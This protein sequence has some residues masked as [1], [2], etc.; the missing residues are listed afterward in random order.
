MDTNIQMSNLE[1][2]SNASAVQVSLESLLLQACSGDAL[3]LAMWQI[4]DKGDFRILGRTY[5]DATRF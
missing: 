3:Q 2:K 5:C 1:C 4:G